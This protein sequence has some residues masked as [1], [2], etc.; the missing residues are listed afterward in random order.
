VDWILCAVGD[1]S[2]TV[3]ALKL[4]LNVGEESFVNDSPA[5][6]ITAVGDSRPAADFAVPDHLTFTDPF[7][8]PRLGLNDTSSCDLE[9]S[10]FSSHQSLDFGFNIDMDLSLM[11][12]QHDV[13]GQMLQA[14]ESDI[15]IAS[16]L[17]D[18]SMIGSARGSHSALT[19]PHNTAT[20][21]PSNM[22]YGSSASQSSETTTSAP[23]NLCNTCGKTFPRR[24][25]L[26]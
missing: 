20:S 15:G 14:I 17:P 6:L 24:C 10:V 9:E 5:N 21:E 2:T 13:S 12:S 4:I 18:Q 11:E 1:P 19:P 23:P 22:G 7:E 25:D 16:S 3:L 8:A 26:K